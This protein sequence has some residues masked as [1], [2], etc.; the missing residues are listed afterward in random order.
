MFVKC[1]KGVANNSCEA[2]M[3]HNFILLDFTTDIF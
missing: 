3:L 1:S 2:F